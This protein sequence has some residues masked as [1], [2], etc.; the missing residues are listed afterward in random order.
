MPLQLGGGFLEAEDKLIPSWVQSEQ[1]G[2][3]IG[4]GAET[5]YGQALAIESFLSNRAP[6]V[7]PAPFPAGKNRRRP[8]WKFS[9]P[10]LLIP[11]STIISTDAA[12]TA[13]WARKHE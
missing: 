8:K 7:Q 10:T 4:S 5:E 9:E 6:L 12:E 1:T 2:I 13:Y 3:G 11:L